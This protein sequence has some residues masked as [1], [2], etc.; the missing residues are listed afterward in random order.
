M[1]VQ[2]LLSGSNALVNALSSF[3]WYKANA[4]NHTDC[5]QSQR[6]S[7]KQVRISSAVSCFSMGLPSAL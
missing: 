1:M 4:C 2:S 7:K 5:R 3:A 6:K